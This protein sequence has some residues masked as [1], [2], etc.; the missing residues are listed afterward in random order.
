MRA[1]INEKRE[2]AKGTL[3]VTFDP[4]G[5]AVEITPGQ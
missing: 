5:A 3:L 4:P 2:V 1:Q